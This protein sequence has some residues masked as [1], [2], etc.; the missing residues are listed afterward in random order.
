MSQTTQR[1]G[2]DRKANR[3]AQESSPYLL[4]HQFN[5]VDWY[6]WGEE[7]FE[8]ARREVL[9]ARLRGGVGHRLR[10]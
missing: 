9:V 2:G 4:Q 10:V 1:E 5:P 6:P 7:A 8:R 3:L